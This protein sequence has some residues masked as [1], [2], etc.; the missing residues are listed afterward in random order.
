M[1]FPM[2]V[3]N[4]IF[5]RHS[6]TPVA[7]RNQTCL[8][9]HL[10]GER[11][12]WDDGAHGERLACNDCH[13]MHVRKDPALSKANQAQNC[14]ACHPKILGTSPPSSVHPLT[15]AKAF[16]CTECHDP[17]GSTSLASCNSC[18]PQD[19]VHLAREP[20]KARSYHERALARQIACTS[21]HKGFVHALPAITRLGATPDP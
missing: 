9:C 5:T 1:T 18:H 19:P 7:K 14:A 4:I 17:H 12:H 20:E 10:E 11:A 8:N 15:G 6:K 21:C 3:G 2:Q 13:V 16:R